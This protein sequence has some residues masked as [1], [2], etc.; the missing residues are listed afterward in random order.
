M[1]KLCWSSLL[2]R[3]NSFHYHNTINTMTYLIHIKDLEVVWSV[4]MLIIAFEAIYYHEEYFWKWSLLFTRFAKK[5]FKMRVL[6]LAYIC[7]CMIKTKKFERVWW[8]EVYRYSGDFIS[9]DI[10]N[11]YSKNVN[12]YFDLIINQ[13]IALSISYHSGIFA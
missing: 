2:Q 7:Q 5:Y 13:S 12:C 10:K 1:N 4:L 11:L 9:I 3:Q 6:N 8:K